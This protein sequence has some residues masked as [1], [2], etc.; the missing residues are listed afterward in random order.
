MKQGELLAW[1][2]APADFAAGVALYAQLGGSAVYQQLFA[3]G[4]TG[5]SRQVLVAQLQLL[6]G[7]VQESVPAP[8]ADNQQPTTN[9]PAPDL[10]VLASVRTQLKA[11][12]D[13]RSH[14]H[15]QLTTPGLRLA[16][17]NKL[18]HRICQLTDQVRQLLSAE[19]HVLAHGRLPGPVA[20]Q[21]VTDAGELHRRLDNLISLRAK[22][23]RR[24]ERAAELPGLEA[25]IHLIREKLPLR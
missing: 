8:V 22:V 17:R 5:Y 13:E 9:Q 12:R 10:A 2:A 6:A 23:R 15:A 14:A 21:D 20:T 18:A 3:L 25:Q 11:A 24:P 19:Q 1:L 16:N 7:P 4:E